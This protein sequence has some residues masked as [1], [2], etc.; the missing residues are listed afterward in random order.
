MFAKMYFNQ[1]L[2]KYAQLLE[3]FMLTHQSGLCLDLLRIN[4]CNKLVANSIPAYYVH[5]GFESHQDEYET[6][7]LLTEH[8]FNA[9]RLENVLY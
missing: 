7:A 3:L 9:I 1:P 8:T 2:S 4:I 5:L 6:W